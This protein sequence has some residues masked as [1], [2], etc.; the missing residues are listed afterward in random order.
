MVEICRNPHIS[1]L[2]H[3]SIDWFKG[4]FTGNSHISWENQW[5]P[6]DFPLSQAIEF[7]IP[8]RRS[9]TSPT[10]S[11]R[12]G[13]CWAAPLPSEGRR[14]RCL[15][16]RPGR[17]DAGQPWGHREETWG[18]IAWKPHNNSGFQHF[19]NQEMRNAFHL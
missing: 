8:A 4:E 11:R 5:F 15:P 1:L 17:N 3:L 10:R 7:G 12:R 9:S 14:T 16:G 6:I 13:R 19:L 18:Q 2:N